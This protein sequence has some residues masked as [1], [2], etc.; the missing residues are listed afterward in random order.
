MRRVCLFL[1]ALGLAGASA[2]SAWGSPGIVPGSFHAAAVNR[3]GTTDMIAGSH[4]YAYTASFEINHDEAGVPE[5]DA[6]TLVVDVPAGFV[7]NPTATPRCDRQEFDGELAN[8]PP[9]TQI[10]TLKAQLVEPHATLGPEGALYNL[11]PPAGVAASFG[12]QG[13]GFNVI[14]NASLVHTPS[15]GSYRVAVTA[16]VPKNG[17]LKASETVWGVPADKSHDA[18]RE[19]ITS[20]FQHVT[21]CSIEETPRPFLSLPTNCEPQLPDRPRSRLRPGPDPAEDP[22]ESSGVTATGG[23]RRPRLI[24]SPTIRVQPETSAAATAT[25]LQV[26]LHMP[27]VETPE[28]LTE[29]DLR[30]ATVT[31]AEG[32]GG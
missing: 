6:R 29:A 7:G 26:D 22:Q 8:C 32:M 31:L 1:C 25:G 21:P 5:A 12:F 14:E 27:Q 4:P 24:S 17:L 23:V 18:E 15:G 3:D 11:V 28:G 20:T 9:S 19:C 10:G 2:G 30:N 13:A 16:N